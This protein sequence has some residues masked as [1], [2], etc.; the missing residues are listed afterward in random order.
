[1]VAVHTE[2]DSPNYPFVLST[3]P[4]TASLFVGSGEFDC[5]TRPL[6]LVVMHAYA[7]HGW[8]NTVVHRHSTSLQTKWQEHYQYSL[9]LVP[10]LLVAALKIF[11]LKN[12]IFIWLQLT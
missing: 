8:T 5:T 9:A 4:I 2:R 12:P 10:S 3:I 1:M 11:R 6:F 7:W